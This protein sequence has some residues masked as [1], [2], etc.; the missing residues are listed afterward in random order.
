MVLCV[1]YRN[2]SESWRPF[3]A[4]HVCERT[5]VLVQPALFARTLYQ[6]LVG[7]T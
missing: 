5:R 3:R 6:L 2:G 7:K 1:L 4:H